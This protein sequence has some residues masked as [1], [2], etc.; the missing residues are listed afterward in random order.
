[1]TQKGVEAFRAYVEALKGYLD[2]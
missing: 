1:M 2:V